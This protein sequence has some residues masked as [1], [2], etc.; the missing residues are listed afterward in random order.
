MSLCTPALDD[1]VHVCHE[2]SRSATQREGAGVR[3][4]ERGEAHDVRLG[5]TQG[6][7]ADTGPNAVSVMIM[8]GCAR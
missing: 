7:R 2:P 3:G 1:L 4:V 8:L 5:I 6:A